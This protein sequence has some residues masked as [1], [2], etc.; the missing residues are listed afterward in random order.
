M[1]RRYLL[2]VAVFLCCGCISPIQA[3][4]VKWIS[5]PNGTKALLYLPED[6]NLQDRRPLLMALHGMGQTPEQILEIWRPVADSLSMIL[7]C[8]KGSNFTEGW[9][10]YPMDD[11]KNL[12]DFFIKIN[13]TY[14]ID[15]LHSVLVGF[16]RGGNFA[17]E[18]G[19]VYPS[20]FRKVICICGFFLDKHELIAQNN[21]QGLPYLYKKSFFYFITG[22]SD[23]THPSLLDGVALFQKNHIATQIKIYP[24]LTHGYPSDLADQIKFVQDYDNSTVQTLHPARQTES[25]KTKLKEKPITPPPSLPADIE[26]KLAEINKTINISSELATPA[27]R[28]KRKKDVPPIKK[29]PVKKVE[30]KKEDVKE[31]A[32]KKEAVK[33]TSIKKA[34]VKKAEVIIKAAPLSS[35]GK[36]TKYNDGK[37]DLP[38]ILPL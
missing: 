21:L 12:S 16:S 24:N 18:T 32:V 4:D 8:P 37:D 28:T 1:F 5:L 17:I 29:I 2:F 9:T 15:R 11:R 36:K 31:V 6:I 19:L 33:K 7:L 30:V 25:S 20:T 23:S 26:H 13:T 22:K 38:V 27:V 34:K 3:K 35:T 14:K 10:R